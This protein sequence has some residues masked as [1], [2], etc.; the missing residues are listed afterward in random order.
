MSF[1]DDLKE[2]S[3]KIIEE[4]KIVKF[5]G[6]D[7]QEYAQQFASEIKAYCAKPWVLRKRK[8]EF[9]SQ[10]MVPDID[11]GYARPHLDMKEL[12]DYSFVSKKSIPS[13]I[14]K[15]ITSRYHCSDFLITD[16]AF[17]EEVAQK[18]YEILNRCGFDKLNFILFKDQKVYKD[19]GYGKDFFRYTQLGKLCNLFYVE[20]EW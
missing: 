20:I 16:T 13:K 4:D 14:L 10:G 5:S 1:A 12:D 18:T 7:T 9:L 15:V 19:N 17:A 3:D 6:F 11:S 2:R 8:V